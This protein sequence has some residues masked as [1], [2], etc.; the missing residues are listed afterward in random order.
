MKEPIKRYEL[1]ELA[2]PAAFSGSQFNIP[3]LQQLAQTSSQDIIIRALEFF[4]VLEIPTSAT[5]QPV[6]PMAQLQAS[7][8]TLYIE[9]EESVRRIP[10][11][12]LRPIHNAGATSFFVED[13][14]LFD[15]VMV[16]WSKSYIEL[17]AG[18]GGGGFSFLM[19]VWYKKLP[20]GGYKQI[21]GNKMKGW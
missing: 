20:A 13:T 10:L 6:V 17:P 14:A 19:G 7:F 3:I 18:F 21:V 1:I 11:V 2:I 4:S 8:L 16:D 9:G 15:N 12:R 5:N